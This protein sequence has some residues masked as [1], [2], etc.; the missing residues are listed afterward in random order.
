M[1]AP[2][3]SAYAAACLTLLTGASA[4]AADKAV[5]PAA[6]ATSDWEK[7]L[8]KTQDVTGSRLGATRVCHTVGEWTAI[9]HSR[10]SADTAH[11]DSSWATPDNRLSH[12]SR[13]R[14]VYQ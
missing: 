12:S 6:K 11:C 10:A 2:L 13:A 4:L 9:S 7:I 14:H 3:L 5:K 8:C 1:H